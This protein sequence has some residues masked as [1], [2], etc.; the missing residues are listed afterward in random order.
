[1]LQFA[2]CNQSLSNLVYEIPTLQSKWSNTLLNRKNIYKFEIAVTQRSAQRHMES[3]NPLTLASQPSKE[4]R[5]ALA[6]MV[7]GK[8]E[9]V[10]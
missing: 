5:S 3:P 4:N 6:R 1:M 9:S 8:S 7:M 2:T 10:Y